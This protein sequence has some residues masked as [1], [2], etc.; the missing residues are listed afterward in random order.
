MEMYQYEFLEAV[1][2]V[3]CPIQCEGVVRG[4]ER[5]IEIGVNGSVNPQFNWKGL[6]GILSD[7]LPKVFDLF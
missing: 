2:S 4:P 3:R 1:G 7:A 6:G 5:M